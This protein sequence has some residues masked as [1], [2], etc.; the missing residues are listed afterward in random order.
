MFIQYNRKITYSMCESLCV[1]FPPFTFVQFV[2][3]P[4]SLMN[5]F[6]DLWLPSNGIHFHHS[7]WLWFWC[8]ILFCWRHRRGRCRF[9]YSCYSSCCFLTYIYF[10][11]AHCS[12]SLCLSLFPPSLTLHFAYKFCDERKKIT[13]ANIRLPNR[14]VVYFSHSPDF[15]LI[16]WQCYSCKFWLGTLSVILL[17][18][19]CCYCY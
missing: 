8:F 6:D 13:F 12:F 14:R 4:L 7:T 9:H 1:F 19:C 2:S 16:F 17:I 3:L 11:L 5:L 10:D 18:R 15:P